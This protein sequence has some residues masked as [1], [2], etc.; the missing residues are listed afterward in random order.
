MREREGERERVGESGGVCG[1][2][3]GEGRDPLGEADK[4]KG[5]V[6]RI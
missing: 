4:F 1:R 5:V 6:G 3:E 2:E